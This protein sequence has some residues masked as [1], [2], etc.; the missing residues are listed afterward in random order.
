MTPDDSFTDCLGAIDGKHVI[1]QSPIHS[2]SEYIKYKEDNQ[3]MFS[4]DQPLSSRTLSLP[5]VIVADDAD[6]LNPR[7]M[8]PYPGTYG[9]RSIE[10]IFNNRLSQARRV[11]NVFG[12]I[13]S[14]FRVLKKP[15]LLEP[16]KAANITITCTLLNEKVK[17]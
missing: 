1:I 6:A 14:V 2:G 17:Y 11:G 3:L 12:I 15:L 13:A 8:K 16:E 7:I 4:P 10:R 9:K 5:F